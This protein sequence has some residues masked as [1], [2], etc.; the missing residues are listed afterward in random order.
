MS[1]KE[2]KL[3]FVLLICF[4]L[5]IFPRNSFAYLDPGTGSII[6]QAIAAIFAGIVTWMSFFKNKIKEYFIKI[7][8][9]KSPKKN[10][11]EESISKDGQ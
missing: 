10:N 1:K 9:K 6:L 3:N 4:F 2:K 8:S 11:K 7:F 5:I